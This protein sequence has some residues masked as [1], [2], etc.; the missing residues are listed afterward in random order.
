MEINRYERIWMTISI[1]AIVVMLVA[2]ALAGFGLGMQL[3]GDAGAVDPRTLAQQPPFN[4]PGVYETA[5]GKYQVIMV[6]QTWAF[7]PAEVRVPVGAEVT[8]KITSRDVT[9][10][11]IIEDT[12]INIMIL[13][14]QVAEATHVFDTPGEYLFVCHEYCGVAHQAMAGK[15]IVEPE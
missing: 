11:V 10:G 13:P 9:H 2:I 8:F 12:N 5:P 4:Q 3:P 15:V 6:A 14:G 1:A 7:N